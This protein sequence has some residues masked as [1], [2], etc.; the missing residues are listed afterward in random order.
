[1]YGVCVRRIRCVILE[2][3]TFNSGCTCQLVFNSCNWRGLFNIGLKCVPFSAGSL[4]YGVCVRRIRC[5]ILEGRTF[6]SGCTCQLVFNSCNWRGLFHIG[7]KC[8][9][10]SAGSLMYGVCVRRIRCVSLE[11]RTFN[12]GC[13]CQLVFNSCNW[14]GLFHIGLKCVTISAGNLM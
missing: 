2:G 5:V 8:V 6:N 4:M 7:L 13:T 11:G 12:S 10:F 3:R 14:R 9:P 1:M